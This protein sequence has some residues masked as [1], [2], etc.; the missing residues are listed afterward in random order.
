MHF[1]CLVIE[2]VF[3]ADT[4][5]VATFHESRAA[6]QK[7][8]DEVQ[9]KVCRAGITSVTMAGPRCATAASGPVSPEQQS[10]K[11][12]NSRSASAVLHS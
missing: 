2:G 9:V 3:A 1:H 4:S 8:R 6:D 5:G 12:W 10:P 7:L 11:Q